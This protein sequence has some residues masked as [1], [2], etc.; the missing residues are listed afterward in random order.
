MV[1]DTPWPPDHYKEF[2]RRLDNLK[3]LNDAA[4]ER[5]ERLM[6]HYGDG[7]EG[8]IAWINDWA[9]TF[10]PRNEDPIPKLM[11]FMMFARQDDF[12]RFLYACLEDKEG[13]LAEKCRDIGASWLCCAFSI[14]LWLF[15]PG[16]VVGW[17]SKDADL[18]D[19]LG[20]P[21]AIFTK[22]RQIIEFLPDWMMPVG[23]NPRRHSTYMK[24]INPANGSTIIGEAG[25]DMGRGGRTSIYFKDESAHYTHPELVEAA[26]G[27]NTN[28][29]IDLSSVNGTNNPFYRR[30]MGGEVWYRDVK[31]TPGMTRIFIFD[32]R[33]HPGK[34]QAWYDARKAKAMREGTMHILAQE[35][36][37]DYAGSV[38]RVIIDPIWARACI[39]A[40][41]KLAHLG[42]F[43]TGDR[44]A[45]QDIADE[46]RDKNALAVRYGVILRYADHW[47]GDAGEA[48]KVAIPICTEMGVR[49]LYYDSI[50]VGAGFKT[51]INN[52]MGTA[53]WPQRLRVFKW[54]AGDKVMD[55]DDPID[56]SDPEG[57]TN[58]Q[59][60]ENL[61]AQAW[62]RLRARIYKTWRA[63]TY[64]DIYHPSELISFP[65]DLPRL[66]EVLAE[67]SQAVHKYAKS[68]KT[69]VDK[70]PNGATSPNMADSI[71][72]C[73]NP[74]RIVGIL[75]VVD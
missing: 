44:I 46:G 40:H 22:M 53:A 51:G 55:P 2:Q 20:D 39:D 38:D 42:N 52:L 56:P 23:F 69:L 3:R 37:R 59:Q 26:L 73:Y 36:D 35:V 13:G 21:A 34:T 10:D 16:T 24:L 49:E 30:R 33:D 67:L 63:I 43:D 14:W 12:I 57:P 8:C 54:I 60:Y 48:A 18:V 58:D 19:K 61:K 28:V 4:P 71:V 70:K 62:W 41:L 11:P 32:W 15:R 17:G 50:G 65:S 66:Q 6:E 31:P 64:G 72:E 74:C 68:G 75:E 1:S 29:Q 25:D 5:R 45:G 47:A 27:D 7:V 9:V